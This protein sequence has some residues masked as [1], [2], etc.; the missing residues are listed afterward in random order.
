MS[1]KMTTYPDVTTA[2]SVPF[3]IYSIACVNRDRVFGIHGVF[4]AD[5]IGPGGIL[6][7]KPSG[8]AFRFGPSNDFALLRLAIHLCVA[9]ISLAAY[10]EALN[11]AVR[12][13]EIG[14]TDCQQES[15]ELHGD[16]FSVEVSALNA[17]KNAVTEHKI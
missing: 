17:M 5:P 3:H 16:A 6:G 11:V 4:M 8:I 13:N 10:G 1:E 7:R 14:T 12:N 2:P 15:E 9:L